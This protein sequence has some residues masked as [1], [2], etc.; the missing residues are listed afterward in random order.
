VQRRVPDIA[1]I[2]KLGFVPRIGL[3]EGVRTC[4]RG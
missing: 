4:W 2:T 3:A 1:K